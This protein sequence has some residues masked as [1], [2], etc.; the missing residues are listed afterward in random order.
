MH[1]FAVLPGGVPPVYC[2][3]DAEQGRRVYS[4]DTFG[5]WLFIT[6]TYSPY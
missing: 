5:A 4:R 2:K 3:G 6:I 1:F